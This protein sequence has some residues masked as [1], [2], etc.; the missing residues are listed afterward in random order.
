MSSSESS[1]AHL[2]DSNQGE[3]GEND[4]SGAIENGTQP[5]M[6]NDGRGDDERNSHQ[7]H[8]GADVMLPR[9]NMGIAPVHSQ[10]DTSLFEKIIVCV[11]EHFTDNDRALTNEQIL[12]L[13]T[14]DARTL[15]HKC[16][17]KTLSSTGT[18]I[19]KSISTSGSVPEMTAKMLAYFQVYRQQLCLGAASEREF[20]L[21]K[22][23]WLPSEDVRLL[24]IF[25]DRDYASATDAAFQRCSRAVLDATD[26]S[27]VIAVWTNVVGPLFNNFDNYRP[28]PRFFGENDIV[29]RQCD[30]NSRNIPRRIPEHLR[31]RFATLRSR[32]T[33]VYEANWKKSGHNDPEKF[34]DYI[35]LQS[36]ID[37]TMLWMFRALHNT[38]NDL[39]LGRM[40]RTISEVAQVD[41]SNIQATLARLTGR[42]LQSPNG[43]S[44]ESSTDPTPPRSRTPSFE[45][46]QELR[47]LVET[48]KQSMT[49]ESENE[50]IANLELLC[51]NRDRAFSQMEHLENRIRSAPSESRKRKYQNEYKH[52]KGEWIELEKQIAK[53]RN[54]AI[55]ETRFIDDES[56]LSLD[57]DTDSSDSS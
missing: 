35:N 28:E 7:D 11:P 13:S 49:G 48:W 18:L 1:H 55:D 2:A 3:P 15:C 23:T 22:T 32:W 54:V 57:S 26:G 39:M 36:P 51:R 5:N 8:G 14:N 27:P 29:L 6:S 40:A 10:M 38:G 17:F 30:P 33:M 47:E 52:H 24:E 16:K 53:K 20:S 4:D 50:K 37:I 9:N 42:R 46:T 25:L 43:N 34:T 56:F 31:S 21:S 45:I 12:L 19:M 44:E 41:S